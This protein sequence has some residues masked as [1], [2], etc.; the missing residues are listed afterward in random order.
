MKFNC[1]DNVIHLIIIS[2]IVLFVSG[3]NST[4]SLP[5]LVISNY[6]VTISDISGGEVNIGGQVCS[7]SC[8]ILFEENQ[9]VS[10]TASVHQGFEFAQWSGDV[11]DGIGNTTCTFVIT[12]NVTV[13]P[14]FE[15]VNTTLFTV[16][17]ISS[18]NGVVS[19]GQSI[20]C[21][22]ACSAE[23]QSD[24]LV[25]LSATVDSGYRFDHWEG[26]VCNN[27]DNAN[28]EFTITDNVSIQAFFL[29]L[30]NECGQMSILCVDDTNGAQQEYSTIQSAINDAAAGDTVLVFSGTY[31]G[32]NVNKSGTENNR[33]TVTSNDENVFV[34]QRG[35]NSDAIIRISDASYVTLEGFT[36]NNQD[37]TTYGIAAR[38]ATVSNPMRGL[39]IKNNKV[40]DSPSTNIYLSQV[41]ESTIEGNIAANSA[42]SHGIYLANGGSDNTILRAN[43]C[44]NNDRNG[45]H[46]N[47]D[48]TVGSS[49][50]GLHTGIIMEQNII[51]ENTANGVDMDGVQSSIIR[52]NLIYG[53]G[54]HALR[55]F[56]I[57]SAEGPKALHIYNNTL[58]GNGS[59]SIKLTADDGQHVI[60]NNI[61]I[62]N[63]GSISVTSSNF[64]SNYNVTTNVFRVDS[65]PEGSTMPLSEWQVSGYGSESFISSANNL[66]TNAGAAVYSLSTTSPA[67][68]SGIDQFINISA[69]QLDIE[70]NQRPVGAGYD[71]GAYENQ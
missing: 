38:G 9:T 67:I 66:F 4:G 57:D 53:N 35:P 12:Q 39:I 29:P 3:C 34:T 28:C 36:V 31:E 5:P 2:V 62:D 1:S 10:L 18:D 27:S 44:Y 60:F 33:L 43:I 52:N 69:P 26:D 59:W 21:G 61:L 30:E 50:D 56:K 71:I 24:E 41:S 22:T 47:G 54:R 32:F 46:F 14:I 20:N 11:C 48:L 17:V 8:T 15:E 63:N 13:M 55:G 58:V 25:S 40:F 7:T 16:N 23:Y 6:T 68:D 51:Y 70:S 49:T 65:D 19:D 64:S 45:I 37:N 42:A